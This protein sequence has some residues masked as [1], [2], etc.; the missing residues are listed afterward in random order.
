M[1][2]NTCMIERMFDRIEVGTLVSHLLV[3]D[4]ALK[5][6]ARVLSRINGCFVTPVSTL[7]ALV[8]EE[9]SGTCLSLIL[10]ARTVCRTP[11]RSGC[12]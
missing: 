2:T 3:V 9:G 4:R 5:R 10:M 11:R 7:L 12:G 8:S 6:A 1:L